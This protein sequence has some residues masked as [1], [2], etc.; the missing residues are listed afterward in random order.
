[1][2]EQPS[3]KTFIIRQSKDVITPLGG[4][5][6]VGFALQKFA[7]IR[8]A[9]DPYYPMKAGSIPLSAILQSYVGLLAQGKSDF[10]AIEDLREDPFYAE[11][12]GIAQIPSA[13]SLRLRLDE[14]AN[15]ELFERVEGLIVP[16]LM[17]AK[18]KFSTTFTGHVPLDADGT[19]YDNSGTKKEHVSR[20]YLGFDG[21]TSL[22]FFL[23]MEGYCL[24]AELR[25]GKEHCA[26]EFGFAL[27]RAVTKAKRLVKD[28]ILARL[29][30]GFDS[31][32]TYFAL[33]A[34]QVD[35][36]VK[37][38]PRM[39]VEKFLA[40]IGDFK[41]LESYICEKPRDG[42]FIHSFKLPITLQNDKGDEL[43][44]WR[45]IELTERHSNAKGQQELI[46]HYELNAWTTNLSLE[47]KTIRRLYQEHGT[48]EQFHSEIKTDMDLNRFPSGK[49]NTNYLILSLASIAYNILRLMGQGGLLQSDSPVRH[50]AKR[51]RIK[52]V[53]Q[54]MM[55][56]AAR[57]VSHARSVALEF[58]RQ[59]QGF[60][61][62][63]RLYA[64]WGDYA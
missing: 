3:L 50:N 60:A 39:N 13:S 29:D 11:A 23:G 32:S 14:S 62:Y 16:L 19:A 22:N 20:T 46:P 21:Y 61:C 24:G 43:T 10:E 25:P 26:S 34:S 1:M 42:K 47:T 56:S 4:M 36:I 12:L 59:W 49:F 58:G 9:L 40:Q 33:S 27:E 8:Q 51:R 55:Y 15:S 41:S 18:A 7:K 45:H 38:N 28:P 54:E 44:L 30:S 37:W 63:E 52:T 31:K 17:N 2:L 48:M 6:F 64:E 57:F 53:I 5:P 35:F